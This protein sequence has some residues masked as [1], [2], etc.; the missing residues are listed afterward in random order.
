MARAPFAID[1]QLT[2][3]AIAYKNEEYIADLIAP[4]RMVNAELFEV[5]YLNID[6]MFELQDDMVGRL[7]APNQVTFSSTRQQ[8]STEDHGLDAP[9]P[10]KDMNNYQGVGASPEAIASE[11]V[12]ELVMLNREVRVAKMVEDAANYKAGMS[13]TLSGTSQWSDYT[14]SNP[15]DAIL[16]ALDEPLVRP[17]AAGTSRS[18]WRVIRQHPKVVEY[19]KG[20]GAGSDARGMISREQF[21]EALEL[22]AFYVGSTRAKNMPRNVS[23]APVTPPR[24]WGKH[25]WLIGN[26]PMAQLINMNRPTFLL[27]AQFGT[28]VSGRIQDP[29][30]GLD[31]GVRIRAGE[32]VKEVV[33]SKECGYLFKNV[34]A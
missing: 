22:D 19:V 27:T 21:R 5:D 31:G 4:R 26:D 8:F 11:G 6:D 18:A 24:I 32:H 12:S 20:T 9:V 2:S 13:A 16:T 29:D 7:S 23:A 14:N 15:M 10:Q 30:M 3:I 25:F 34:V 17:T 1:P 33:I 28:K